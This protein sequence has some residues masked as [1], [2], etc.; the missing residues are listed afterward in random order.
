MDTVWTWST[1]F[2]PQVDF[3]R[4]RLAGDHP[5]ELMI[6]ELAARHSRKPH[7]AALQVSRA[8]GATTPTPPTSSP[9]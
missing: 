8:L 7:W 6:G 2:S 1:F 9:L 3:A 5:A 4:R